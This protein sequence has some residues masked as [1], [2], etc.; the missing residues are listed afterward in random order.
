MSTIEVVGGPGLTSA[1]HHLERGG[2]VTAGERGE[3]TR[4][5]GLLPPAALWRVVEA[6]APQPV[7]TTRS[8]AAGAGRRRRRVRFMGEASEPAMLARRPP[9]SEGRNGNRQLPAHTRSTPGWFA[10]R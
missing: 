8:T 6:L 9:G 5:P 7:S 1:G 3:N 4:V 2:V 10:R